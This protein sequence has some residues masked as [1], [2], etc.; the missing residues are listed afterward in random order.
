MSFTDQWA[1]LTS[2]TLEYLLKQHNS[3]GGDILTLVGEAHPWST[4]IA[5]PLHL[6]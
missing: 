1:F 3:N 2:A 5:R 6:I 4:L